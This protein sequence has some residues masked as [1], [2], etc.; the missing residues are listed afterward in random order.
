MNR[1][2]AGS[3][4]SSRRPGREYAPRRRRPKYGVVLFRLGGATVDRPTGERVFE[5]LSSTV[6]EGQ[7]GPPPPAGGRR[8]SATSCSAG[9][10]SPP[11]WSSGRWSTGSGPPV[12]K[13]P[14]RPRSSAGSGSRRSRGCSRTAGTTTSSGST[15]S[16]RDD[17]LTLTSSS[18]RDG[19]PEEAFR[20]VTSGSGS[21]TCG[22]CP[23]SSSR[24]ARPGPPGSPAR[25]RPSRGPGPRRA[26][27]RVDAD[28]R[29]EVR[30]LLRV[31]DGWGNPPGAVTPADAVPIGSRTC[32]G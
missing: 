21:P 30:A 19:R 5:G 1:S 26:V 4:E 9:S 24:T 2:Q 16:S 28:G 22:R 8:P 13:S 20:A 12:G 11:V 6:R 10:G 14:G 25:A 18:T 27:R 29:R 31:T 15:S 32:W 23:S 3:A 17:D 7:T